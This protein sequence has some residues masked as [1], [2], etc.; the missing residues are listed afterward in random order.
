MDKYLDEL[1]NCHK[2]IKKGFY[3]SEAMPSLEEQKELLSIAQTCI[4]LSKTLTQ[5]RILA[6][7]KLDR[8]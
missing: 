7:E 2:Q 6:K 5:L 4:E 8:A 1:K 3:T